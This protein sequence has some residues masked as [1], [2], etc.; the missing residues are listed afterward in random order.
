MNPHTISKRD[1]VTR[2]IVRKEG[3]VD[4]RSRTIGPRESTEEH[5]VFFRKLRPRASVDFTNLTLAMR[6]TPDDG[7][8]GDAGA[9][10]PLNGTR[11]TLA[12][13]GI[14]PAPAVLRNATGDDP[15]VLAAS[16]LKQSQIIDNVSYRRPYRKEML[17]ETI[18]QGILVLNQ[19]W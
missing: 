10:A 6:R 16:L 1:I 13:S 15:D 18:R 9:G 17:R 8:S 14:G 12:A 2:I 3:A 11:F 7:S 5:P 19:V 4:D